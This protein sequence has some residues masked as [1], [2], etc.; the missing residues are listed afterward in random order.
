M[1]TINQKILLINNNHEQIINYF[2][3]L[4]TIFFIKKTHIGT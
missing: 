2:F 4:P 1:I 3:V